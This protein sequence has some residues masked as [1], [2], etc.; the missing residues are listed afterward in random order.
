MFLT[1]KV[2]KFEGRFIGVARGGDFIPTYR[3]PF[4]KSESRKIGKS[5]IRKIGKSEVLIIVN[6]GI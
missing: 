2:E 3:H 1:K 5:Y 4:G 6:S